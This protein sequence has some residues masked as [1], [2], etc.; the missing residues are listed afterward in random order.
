MQAATARTET[1][2]AR[3]RT[4]IDVGGQD[5]IVISWSYPATNGDFSDRRF[6]IGGADLEPNVTCRRR[7][8]GGDLHPAVRRPGPGG[9][10]AEAAAVGAGGDPVVGHVTFRAA[11]LEVVARH[12]AE[13]PQVGPQ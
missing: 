7:P 1:P 9:G 8:E 10:V 12:I 13:P 4:N 3:R 11:L 5:V 6:A 2:Q